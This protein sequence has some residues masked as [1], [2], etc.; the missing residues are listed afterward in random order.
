VI[1][2][3]F[4]W[5]LRRVR[6]FCSGKSCRSLP[7][8]FPDGT[9]LDRRAYP[10]LF[11]TFVRLHFARLQERRTDWIQS[12]ASAFLV[13]GI[14]PVSLLCFWVAYLRRHDLRISGFQG[15]LFALSV[16]LTAFQIVIAR[17]IL[18]NEWRECS[19]CCPGKPSS[20]IV[21]LPVR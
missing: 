2:F 17:P 12:L 3:L 20:G 10:T 15:L 21:R 9:P 7:A 1:V 6:V 8:Y 14:P 19:S 16:G 18:R 13:F 4:Q 11:N 5:L